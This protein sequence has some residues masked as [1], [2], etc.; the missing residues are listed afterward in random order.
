MN[1]Q[2][3]NNEEVN[4]ENVTHAVVATA[5]MAKR[6]IDK[7]SFDDKVELMSQ[8]LLILEE[9]GL[10]QL[11]NVMCDL[12]KIQRGMYAANLFLSACAMVAKS[13]TERRA[14]ATKLDSILAR[15]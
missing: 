10:I 8:Y 1:D 4:S 7:L 11:D 15:S 6:T 2:E 3:M 9:G 5:L 13:E 14:I 12:E